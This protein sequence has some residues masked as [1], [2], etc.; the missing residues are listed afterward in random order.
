MPGNIR[1]Q[2]NPIQV[3]DFDHYNIYR[4]DV[5][6]GDTKSETFLDRNL[7]NGSY[8]YK[9]SAVDT[10]GNEGAKSSGITK[11]VPEDTVAPNPPTNLRL[12]LSGDGV[13]LTWEG[14]TDYPPEAVKFYIYVK[15][16]AVPYERI[17]ITSAWTFLH[18][19]VPGGSTYDYTVTAVD[20]YDNES[21]SG[22]S[23]SISVPLP[24][25]PFDLVAIWNGADI[26]LQ[27]ETD[28]IGERFVRF[29]I[30]RR[31][32][33]ETPWDLVGT[34]TKLNFLDKLVPT[35]VVDY[36]IRKVHVLGEYADSATIPSPVP[37]TSATPT[38][39][40]IQKRDGNPKLIWDIDLEQY[41]ESIIYLIWLKIGAGS[42][43]QIAQTRS[44]SWT[45]EKPIPAGTTYTFYVE[46]W[47]ELGRNV[48]SNQVGITYT[49]PSAPA[50]LEA[51]LKEDHTVELAWDHPDELPLDFEIEL[52]INAGG[53]IKIDEV[54][55]RTFTYN[56]PVP[57]GDSYVFRV[58]ARDPA[59]NLSTYSNT[60]T[61]APSGPGTPDD[62]RIRLKGADIVLDW[63]MDD[64]ENISHFLI[65]HK[66]DAGSYELIDRVT[67]QAFT[68]K[69]VP[70]NHTYQYKVAAVD[71]A[72]NEGTQSA[73]VTIDVDDVIAPFDLL[74]FQVGRDIHLNWQHT[75]P[76]DQRERFKYFIILKK[77]SGEATFDLI[78]KTSSYSFIDADVE[79]INAEYKIKAIYQLDAEA[80]ATI[81]LTFTTP[82]TPSLRAR[83]NDD[84]SVNLFWDMDKQE[85][86]DTITFEIE[87]DVGGG[88]Y[89]KIA[90]TTSQSFKYSPKV[91]LLI[92]YNFRIRAR[93]AFGQVSSYS[94]VVNFNEGRPP[95][96][97]D[98]RWK[99]EG[100]GIRLTWSHPGG[101]GF[102]EDEIA[103]YVIYASKDSGSVL[104]VGKSTS[105]SWVYREISSGHSYNF[106]IVAVNKAG[107][108]SLGTGLFPV[109]LDYPISP[110]APTVKLSGDNV[111]IFWLQESFTERFVAFDV[112]KTFLAAFDDQFNYTGDPNPGLWNIAKGTPTVNGSLLILLSTGDGDPTRIV[113][114]RSFLYA[115]GEIQI[116]VT[117]GNAGAVPTFGGWRMTNTSLHRIEIQPWSTNRIRFATYENGSAEL[118]N[119]TTGVNLNASQKHEII[120]T[121]G[122]VIFK[123]GGV[124][125]ATHSTR[126]PQ[127]ELNLQLRAVNNVSGQQTEVDWVTLT[128][129]ATFVIGSTQLQTFTEKNASTLD[130]TYAVRNRHVL[131]EYADSPPTSN[132]FPSLNTPSAM[133]S[134]KQTDND[135]ELNWDYVDILDLP[136]TFEVEMNKDAGGWNKIAETT[137]QNY[138]YDIPT[139]GSTYQFRV[140]ARDA[141]DRTSAYSGTTSQTI[142]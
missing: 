81:S 112:L 52:N 68:H 40:Y 82:S 59:G 39:R 58:R 25:A 22:A 29:E 128:D 42:F 105:T 134:R 20:E 27:W 77:D 101:T 13:R 113:A 84:W 136:V 38:L 62:V 73:E 132:T 89:N 123:I 54:S 36:K 4:D 72:G 70:E 33:G 110:I 43:T 137:S 14:P 28:V 31:Q 83:L 114:R 106:S 127:V 3:A 16:G 79:P 1:L 46:A 126:V 109:V 6:V 50:D 104:Q 26:Q 138:R 116:K 85:P 10:H 45:Y 80:N 19:A 11:T 124:T 94:N 129:A 71:G 9:V 67:A 119:I 96:P 55:A 91:A 44:Q 17:G 117:T 61:V 12:N 75:L 7:A 100:A 64:Q 49:A 139:S 131:D 76:V 115:S 111:E 18:R 135:I 140:R 118:T 15:V 133:R 30:Y 47:D 92:N 125:K 23:G 37:G 103:Y 78:G 121:A 21:T 120:W 107:I 98:P 53:Y 141:F 57:V 48:A 35:D 122:S 56:K 142:P 95:A 74:V 130:A 97:I 66:L 102:T 63:S 88:G 34:T 41:D 32:T 108:E 5:L 2:W 99:L 69:N 8:V 93:D 51:S 87:A 60:Q 24:T 90:E 86:L 65:Y